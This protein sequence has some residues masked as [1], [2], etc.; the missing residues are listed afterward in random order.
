MFKKCINVDSKL[1]VLM[2][3]DNRKAI[4]FVNRPFKID[5]ITFESSFKAIRRYL[6]GI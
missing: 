6:I 3:Q 4:V 1:Q 2:L 5:H